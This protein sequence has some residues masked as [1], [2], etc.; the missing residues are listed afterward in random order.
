MLIMKEKIF[1]II[2]IKQRF[3]KVTKIQTITEVYNNSLPFK[4]KC[5]QLI[6]RIKHLKNVYK[7][8][9]AATAE[10][11]HNFSMNLKDDSI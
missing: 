9:W 3:P 4:W 5:I 7:T 8:D 11:L 6:R 1:Y 10:I 2:N